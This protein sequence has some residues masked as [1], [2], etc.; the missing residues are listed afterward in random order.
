[1]VFT[2]MIVGMLFGC[3]AAVI[4]FVSGDGLWGMIGAYL[5]WGHLSILSMVTYRF[6]Q[7]T[8]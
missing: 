6:I 3:I 4:S 8:L 1:M 2:Y 5:L 7:R